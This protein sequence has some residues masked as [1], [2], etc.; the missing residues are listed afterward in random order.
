MITVRSLRLLV[1]LACAAALL[2]LGRA[3]AQMI[4]IDDV[5]EC[6]V[7]VDFQGASDAKFE[8][9]PGP[10]A[11]WSTV[12]SVL[13][14]NPD[15]EGPGSSSAAAF[16]N[17]NFFPG[18]FSMNG[19]TG[20]S[21]VILP[22]SYTALSAAIFT[23]RVDTCIEYQLDT[24][25]EPGDLGSERR[26]RLGVPGTN[27]NYEEP[28]G[29]SIPQHFE[30][31]LPAGTYEA[32]GHSYIISTLENTQGPVYSAIWTCQPCITT[33]GVGGVGG[34]PRDQTVGCGATAV[35][36]V[37]PRVPVPPTLTYQWRRNLVPITNNG[38]FAG[39]TTPML[40]IQNA[41]TAD[42]GYY[43]VVLSNGTIIEPSRLAQLTVVATTTG[44]EGGD[45]TSPLAFSVRLAGPNPFI[46]STS[47]R[48]VTV[49]PQRASIAVYNAAGAKVRTLVDDIVSGSGVVTWDGTSDAGSRVP[50]GIYFMRAE[51]GSVRESRKVVLLR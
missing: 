33:L 8:Y 32:E 4:P 38:H 29:A 19:G 22:G 45:E 43:D 7:T 11:H 41:C 21:W 42:A 14:E 27:L 9:P 2:A 17:S 24:Q 40:S 51:A 50:S 5:R 10:F 44:V 3:Q 46:G 28:Q 26:L 18:G 12:V 31:R 34:G 49:K 25:Y 37:Q 35:F 13:V 6:A 30:G 23:F 16:Q 48:Y 47:F 15:P 39:V 1:P 20:G 36:T